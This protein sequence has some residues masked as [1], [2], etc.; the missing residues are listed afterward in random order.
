MLFT[1]PT[2][3][4]TSTLFTAPRSP[5]R[6]I[7][8]IVGVLV[9]SMQ[10]LLV[11]GSGDADTKQMLA[12]LVVRYRYFWYFSEPAVDADAFGTLRY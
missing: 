7:Q 11:T 3:G 12:M 8:I 2:A 10:M 1:T 4:S 5:C 6:S 9:A